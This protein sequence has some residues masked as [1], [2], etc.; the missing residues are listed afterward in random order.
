MKKLLASTMVGTLLLSVSCGMNDTAN[1][2]LNNAKTSAY[3]VTSN[4]G[5]DDGYVPGTYSAN[6]VKYYDGL[7][8][9]YGTSAYGTS[10]YKATNNYNTTDSYK[11]VRDTTDANYMKNTYVNT[12]TMYQNDMYKDLSATDFNNGLVTY[13][14]NTDTTVKNTTGVDTAKVATNALNYNGGASSVMMSGV[15]NKERNIDTVEVDNTK[16]DNTKMGTTTTKTNTMTNDNTVN[17]ELNNTYDEMK[18][19]T[20][21]LV[22]DVATDA[23]VAVNKAKIETQKTMNSLEY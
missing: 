21:T 18:T 3:S 7:Y 23:K 1:T 16:V 8:N 14:H 6:R 13:D 19:A 9:D 4:S 20:K 5:M 15:Y 17:Y 22:N 10:A 2:T 12:N 11:D